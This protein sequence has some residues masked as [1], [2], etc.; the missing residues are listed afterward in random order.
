MLNSVLEH[1][2]GFYAIQNKLLLL[3]LLYTCT[4]L[5]THI[6]ICQTVALE[7]D[8]LYITAFSRGFTCPIIYA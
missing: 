2:S 8:Q 4:F 3:L 6:R 5:N 7:E 1:A